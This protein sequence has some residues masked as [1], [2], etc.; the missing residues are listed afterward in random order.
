MILKDVSGSASDLP[1][2]PANV[3]IVVIHG[4]YPPGVTEIIGRS[5]GSFIGRVNEST[6]LKYPS[7]PGDYERIKIEAKLLAILGDHPRIISSKGLNEHGLAL[8]YTRNG[9]LYEHITSKHA[10]ISLSQKLSL[11]KQA[12]E[13]V[14][15]IHEKRVIHC[16][17]NLRNILLDDNF[18]IILADFQGML[19]S[20]HG[21]TLLDGLSR[22]CTKSFMSRSHGDF[23]DVKTDIFA[24]GSA[25]Y[26]IMLGHEVFRNLIPLMTMKMN[27]LRY[28]SAT[29]TSL[30]MTMHVLQSQIN[31]GDRHMNQLKILFKTSLKYK[32]RKEPNEGT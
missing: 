1:S 32:L 28:C 4:Y 16:D 14:K 27:R 23:A 24:L 19:K 9:N 11:C 13:A 29:E 6:V 7:I 15:Y 21:E 25:I 18:N 8:Q 26:F 30:L 2:A 5:S 22:E 31:A 12:S 10:T 3:E 20:P 17:I